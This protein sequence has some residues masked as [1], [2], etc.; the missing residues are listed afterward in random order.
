M[1]GV[2][3][4]LAV[5]FFLL[6]LWKKR[7][8]ILMHLLFQFNLHHAYFA[9]KWISNNIVLMHIQLKQKYRLTVWQSNTVHSRFILHGGTRD[10]AFFLHESIPSCLPLT[11]LLVENLYFGKKAIFISYHKKKFNLSRIWIVIIIICPKKNCIS[12]ALNPHKYPNGWPQFWWKR[13]E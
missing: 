13:N 2:D 10:H 8:S 6:L 7:N 12:V 3:N 4:F 11:C 1:E 5:N 9:N